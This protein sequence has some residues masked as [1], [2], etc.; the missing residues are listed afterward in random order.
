MPGGPTTQH[1]SWSSLFSNS[2][3]ASQDT[4]LEQ[5]DINEVDGISDVPLDLI[6]RGETVWRD[7]LVGFFLEKRLS[8][9]YVQSVLQQKWKTR[10]SFE[11]SADQELFYFK[12]VSDEDRQA[13]LDEGPVFM[14]GRCLVIGPWTQ[15]VE[16]QMKSLNTIP[17]WVKMHN[18]PKVMQTDEG[19]GFIASK[20]GKPHCQDRLTKE[21]RGLDYARVCVEYKVNETLPDSFDIRLSPNNV[22]KISYEYLWIPKRCDYCHIF[23][24]TIDKCSRTGQQ[25]H[26]QRAAN[27]N[28]AGT[29]ARGFQNRGNNAIR[30]DFGIDRGNNTIINEQGEPSIPNDTGTAP[31][32]GDE[33]SEG[34]QAND[35][36]QETEEE[37]NIGD[38]VAVYNGTNIAESS[39]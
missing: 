11:M 25:N 4:R 10:G 6:M 28:R 3:L 20:V 19:L 37:E 34:I 29:D 31:V 7:Y 36:Q 33:F 9:P 39:G 16:L 21:R 23:G 18:V 14:G 26:G 5:F 32:S 22:R 2:R 24:H 13:V 12:F 8:F 30:R 15:N 38:Q 27:K 1:F 17:I 35:A